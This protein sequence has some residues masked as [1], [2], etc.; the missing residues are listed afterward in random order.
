MA[1]VKK[2][3]MACFKKSKLNVTII[4]E[5]NTDTVLNHLNITSVSYV[6]VVDAEKSSKTCSYGVVSQLSCISCALGYV[7]A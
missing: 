5:T 7:S 4:F 6:N 1:A 2:T 3:R